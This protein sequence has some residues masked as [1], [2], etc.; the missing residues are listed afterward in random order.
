MSGHSKWSSIKHKKALTDARKGQQFTKMARE[1]TI[2]AREG[3]GNPEGNY[4]LRLAI[5]KARDVNMPQDNVKRAIMRG[6]GELG[7]AQME[8]LRF[9]GYGP[10]GV[11]VMVETVTDNRNRTSGDIRNLFSRAGGNL[12]TTGSVG[13]MFTRQGQIVVDADGRDPD[14]VGLEAIDL[15]ATDARV[16]GKTVDVVTDPATLE[17]VQQGLKKKGYKIDSAEVTMNSSQLVSLNEA[18]APPVLRLLDAL[19]ELD[20]V[21]SVYSNI[22]VPA[23]V[24]ERISERV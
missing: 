4:R 6:T 24:M 11:A 1:I 5:E 9:E 16:D 8:Q 12:G 13:W 10:H 7:G 17:A 14:E 22:D 23:D 20:D 3:G 2:A 15:G 18:T 19:E 21:Q